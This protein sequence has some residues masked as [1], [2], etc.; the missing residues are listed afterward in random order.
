M[1][2]EYKFIKFNFVNLLAGQI[3]LFQTSHHYFVKQGTVLLLMRQRIYNS[4]YYHRKE[5]SQS[6][7]MAAQVDEKDH[8]KI[9]KQ[10]DVNCSETDDGIKST[11]L[12]MQ[13]QAKISIFQPGITC[14]M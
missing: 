12:K 14:T 11:R 6:N 2:S 4:R 8:D 1:T 5:K 10:L 3:V 13:I 7:E 9:Y